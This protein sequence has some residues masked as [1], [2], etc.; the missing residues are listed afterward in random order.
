MDELVSPPAKALLGL[1]LACTL[2]L[3]TEVAAQVAAQA[4][5]TGA[6]PQ[7]VQARQEGAEPVAD[8][9]ALAARAK[10]LRAAAEK[11]DAR[12]Q[13]QLGLAYQAGE[14]V[15]A[16]DAEAVKWY[17]KAAEA[18]DVIG[19]GML[20]AVYADGCGV[21]K[22]DAEAARWFRKAA[23]AGYPDSLYRLGAM[24]FEVKARGGGTAIGYNSP[25]VRAT[26]YLYTSGFESIPDGIGSKPVTEAL[27]QALK[28]IEAAARRGIYK[29]VSAFTK[30][31]A[32]LDPETG[33]CPA[34]CA[35]FTMV[36]G[37]IGNDSVLYVF[38]CR[39]RIVKLRLTSAVEE[40]E[41]ARTE[42]AA[43]L[44]AVAAWLR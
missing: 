9:E 6:G 18:G 26:V 30:S 33:A 20:G 7:P 37:G 25:A 43:F 35:R 4:A 27:D 24:H 40:A 1:T 23:D 44:K 21:E 41:T 19:M 3:T 15:Q 10:A 13:A 38:G 42:I 17:R 36:Q 29:N 32:A 5:D 16:S 2:A 34:L 28:D 11:G 14:G 8:R 39:N 22:N 31:K 12:S